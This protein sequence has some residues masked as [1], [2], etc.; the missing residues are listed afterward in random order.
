MQVSLGGGWT[1]PEAVVHLYAPALGVA[2]AAAFAMPAQIGFDLLVDSEAVP[3]A[4]WGVAAAGGVVAAVAYM[5]SPMIYARGFFQAAPFLAEATRTL[6]GPP[7]PP[8]LPRF[9]AAIRDPAFRLLVVQY[10]RLTPVPSLRLGLLLAATVWAVFTGV[11][12]GKLSV[13]LVV[14]LLWI[15][16]ATAVAAVS[17]V[18]DRISAPLPLSD[19]ARAR[20]HT[21]AFASLLLP[22]ALCLAIIAVA[23]LPTAA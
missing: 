8:A 15:V 23:W 13:V 9:I 11:D 12:L 5:A 14:A 21:K 6:A 20:G 18:R 7:E 4:L 3:A 19:Q 16:P 10:W 17:P 1:L 2:T 22:V